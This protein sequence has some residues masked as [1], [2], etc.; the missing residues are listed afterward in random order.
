VDPT[1]APPADAPENAVIVTRGIERDY[2]TGSEVV[3]ALRGIDVTISRNEFVA[4]MGPSGSGKST[5]MNVIG[6]L[7][8]PS[9]GEYWLNRQRVSDLHENDL[10]RIRNRE[11]GFVF[12]SFNLLPR[13]TAFQNVELPLVYAGIAKAERGA[14]AR[15]AIEKVGLLHRT[16]HRP[17]ELSG[18]EQQRVAIARAL[19]TRPS[20]L[21]ADEPTG[22]LDSSTGAEVMRLFQE[23]HREGQ[24]LIIITHETAIAERALRQ[25][26]LRDG[27]LVR[28]LRV[29]RSA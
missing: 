27:R 11:I 5:L 20:I 10:A 17:G 28:D 19:V 15:E 6:C 24:T 12:Q 25:L 7:D 23:L 2:R 13:A 4:I 26:H 9:A 18:G 8:A 3:H 16:N 1:A 21:L 22:N 14:A 29:E